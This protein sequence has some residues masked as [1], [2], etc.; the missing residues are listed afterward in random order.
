MGKA[1]KARKKIERAT[2]CTS[3]LEASYRIALYVSSFGFDWSGAYDALQ[4]VKEEVRE[5]ERALEAG[6]EK[7]I[8]QEIGDIF[9]ALANVSRL[10]G[11]NPEKALR[12]TNEKFMK[13]F[14][15]VEKKLKEQGKKLG[16]ASL[17]EMDKFWEESKKSK[18][19]K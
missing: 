19:K 13:R 7:E 6:E 1:M 11:V 8:S 12:K 2:E 10:V 18:L 14:S 17:E 16:Q 15:F 4:K 5:L 9:F 3:S